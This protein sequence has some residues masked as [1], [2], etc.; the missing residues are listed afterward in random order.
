[1]L[2][3]VSISF[4]SLQYFKRIV[5][6]SLSLHYDKSFQIKNE[7]KQN[8]KS[9]T[10]KQLKYN[11]TQWKSPT[12]PSINN[13]SFPSKAK[14]FRSHHRRSSFPL[15]AVFWLISTKIQLSTAFHSC[16]LNSFSFVNFP[17]S[18]TT[19]SPQHVNFLMEFLN[20]VKLHMLYVR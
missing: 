13:L 18:S 15:P 16:P 4:S 6:A 10:Q 20:A 9:N 2:V 3:E 8:K 17:S 5:E 11:Q 14:Y 7:K 12:Q 19:V 1:M